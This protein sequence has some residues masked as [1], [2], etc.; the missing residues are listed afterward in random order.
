M[1]PVRSGAVTFPPPSPR[2]PSAEG[3]GG[4]RQM[5][6]QINTRRVVPRDPSGLC[7]RR[8]LGPEDGVGR[9]GAVGAVVTN[10]Q[11]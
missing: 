7:Q 9:R 4:V 2:C 5:P 11:F 6:A 8:W 10:E 3:Q 1:L